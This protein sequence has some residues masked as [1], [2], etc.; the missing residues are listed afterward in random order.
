MKKILTFGGSNSKNSISRTLAKHLGKKLG[1]FDIED[2]DLNDFE[3]PLYSID[4]EQEFGFPENA[5]LLDDKLSS[6]DGIIIVLAEHNGAYSAVFKN[7]FDWLSRINGEVWKQKPMLL[8]ST[9]PGVR[10]GESVLE[11]AK[12]RFPRN[13]GNIVGS[14]TFP[15]FNDNFKN[16]EIV[17]TALE[18]EII[19]LLNDLRKEL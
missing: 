13:G 4:R 18:S 5:K 3:L 9:S 2:I 8:L 19:S 1:N 7:M 11:I 14:M 16:G 12:N 17:N 15:N 10:G 6:T